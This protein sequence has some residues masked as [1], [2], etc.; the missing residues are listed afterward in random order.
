[1][2][3]EATRK[4]DSDI[5]ALADRLIETRAVIDEANRLYPPIAAISRTS[6][7]PDRLA[8]QSIPKGTMIVIAPY[9]LHRHRRLWRNPDWFDP[10]RFPVGT[11]VDRFA[12]MPFGAGARTC[13]GATFALQEATIVVATLARHFRL[14]P[15]P[16]ET[17][18]PILKVTLRPGSGVRLIARRR[19][20]HRSGRPSPAETFC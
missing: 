4:L 2:H 10:K 9:V 3:S 17:V 14:E 13:I 18:S 11:P 15:A 12:Y 19:N 1:V 8:G 5:G 16:G 7:G 6:L 20:G